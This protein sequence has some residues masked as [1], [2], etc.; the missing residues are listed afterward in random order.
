MAT[1]KSRTTVSVG[2]QLEHTPQRAAIAMSFGRCVQGA[3]E[4]ASRPFARRPLV[5]VRIYARIQARDTSE[6]EMEPRWQQN[7]L[8]ICSPGE[9]AQRE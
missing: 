5:A 1:N 8:V 7:P 2:E 6:E 3:Q 4:V 9:G